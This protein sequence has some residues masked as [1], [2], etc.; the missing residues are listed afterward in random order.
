MRIRRWALIVLVG[1][2]TVGIGPRSFVQPAAAQVPPLVLADTP[3]GGAINDLAI[4]VPSG[5]VSATRTLFL[6]GGSTATPTAHVVVDADGPADVLLSAAG[7][8]PAAAVDVDLSKGEAPVVATVSATASG[9]STV[10]IYATT[11][12]GV[13]E[14]GTI[15]VNKAGGPLQIEGGGSD[16]LK[17][18]ST[19]ADFTLAFRVFAGDAAARGVRVDVD[20]FVAPDG[21]VVPVSLVE[22]QPVVA[23]TPPAPNNSTACAPAVAAAPPDSTTTTSVSPTGPDLQPHTAALVRVNAALPF[24]SAYTSSIRVSHDGIDDPPVTLSVTRAQ[25]APTI[26]VLD[27]E[28]SRDTSWGKRR[29]DLTRFVS[30]RETA[31]HTVVLARPQVVRFDRKTGSVVTAETG[32]LRAVEDVT[33]QKPTTCSG[34][35]VVAAGTTVRLKLK[36]E[37]PATAGEYTASIRFAAAGSTVIDRPA[38]IDLRRPISWAA[39]CILLG[40]GLSF[41]YRFFFVQ[42]RARILAELPIADARMEIDRIR[43]VLHVDAGPELDLLRSLEASAATLITRARQGDLDTLPDAVAALADRVKAASLWIVLTRRIDTGPV[44]LR[45]KY[46]PELDG[47]RRK[48]EDDQIPKADAAKLSTELLAIEDRFKADLAASIEALKPMLPGL[49]EGEA[50][51]A[52]E[53]LLDDAKQ[54]AAAGNYDGASAAVARAQSEM[55]TK[56][57]DDLTVDLE[58][59]PDAAVG[60]SASEWDELKRPIEARLVQAKNSSDPEEIL[61]L[62]KDAEAALIGGYARLVGEKA[63][64]NVDELSAVVT[65]T[66]DQNVL[67][68]RAQDAVKAAD[69]SK[70]L[71]ATDLVAAKAK[72]GVA[73]KA[74]KGVPGGGNL[75][76]FDVGAVFRRASVAFLT[77]PG[78][79]GTA[80]MVVVRSRS[81]LQSRLRKIEIVN[82]LLATFVALVLGL[83]FLY[84][85]HDTWGSFADAAAAIIWGLGVQQLSGQAFGGVRGLQDQLQGGIH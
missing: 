83:Q 51:A 14:L 46:R 50:L 42:P 64:V 59:P 60:I 78:D 80:P 72:L 43:R 21:T 38:T 54:A 62:Y 28:I 73:I 30:I 34:D 3:G 20:A 58:T 23:A 16:G 26:E 17:V 18:Q 22:V 52:V 29:H 27:T 36:L 31:G 76:G 19:T 48:I 81:E 10:H 15:R 69:E 85:S 66:A 53:K 32:I 56:L 77:M 6:R 24:G 61:R 49:L 74:F 44:A 37:F 9:S 8:T 63:Q 11:D 1:S 79:A 47:E 57:I 25:V 84:V 7:S 71:V 55:A 39:F 75:E 45:P 5:D 41:V 33:G 82:T 13:V 70:Q 2:A 68:A 35:I 65:R 12:A 67:L 40:L 4:D